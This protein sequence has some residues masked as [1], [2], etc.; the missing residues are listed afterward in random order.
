[1]SCSSKFS[2]PQIDKFTPGPGEYRVRGGDSRRICYKFRR[3]AST[4]ER[5]PEKEKEDNMHYHPNYEYLEP[6]RYTSF[7]SSM[8][9]KD[10]YKVDKDILAS[11]AQYNL[12]TPTPV[13]ESHLDFQ[14]A[15]QPQRRPDV[16]D[17]MYDV[18]RFDALLK[19]KRLYK[20]TGSQ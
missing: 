10:F 17:K 13:R 16:F 7:I 20:I 19:S 18:S 1:M 11:P 9:R 8:P 2:L 4:V 3:A 6:H 5:R 12:Q 15:R 14:R